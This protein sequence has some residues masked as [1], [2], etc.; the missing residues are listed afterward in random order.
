[1]R[2]NIQKKPVS[3]FVI[4]NFLIPKKRSLPISTASC[5]SVKT[6]ILTASCKSVKKYL[7]SK[8]RKKVITY[9][10]SK[11]QVCGKKFVQSK[12]FLKLC[13]VTSPGKN[14]AGAHG[15]MMPFGR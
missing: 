2:K 11:L 6:P 10:D 12:D 3:K 15:P 5:K 14:P 8:K 9:F 1:M 7:M 13:T 4:A